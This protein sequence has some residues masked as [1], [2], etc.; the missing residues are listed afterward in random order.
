MSRKTGRYRVRSFAPGRWVVDEEL[1]C[2]IFRKRTRW[3]C[4][5]KF[6]TCSVWRPY[7]FDSE[8]RAVSFARSCMKSDGE[9]AAFVP[10]TVDVDRCA[11]T[12]EARDEGEG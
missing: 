3:E 1:L 6:T 12:V 7:S 11:V 5:S 8:A 9:W 2:G 10:R 4:V